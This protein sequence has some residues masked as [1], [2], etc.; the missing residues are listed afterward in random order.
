MKDV[1]RNTIDSYEEFFGTGLYLG[2]FWLAV[3]ALILFEKE[4]KKRE[5][6]LGQILVFFAVYLFPAS[7]YLIM[8]YCIGDTVY[9]RMFWLLP[10]TVMISY[11][12][13][14]ALDYAK[15]RRRKTVVAALLVFAVIQGGSPVYN[16][17]NFSIASNYYK[18][19]QDVL[20]VCEAVSK[21][22]RANG[23]EKK[24]LVVPNQLATE[25]RQYD[26]SIRMPY[27]RNAI[28]GEKISKTA[29]RIY[30]AVNGGNLDAAALSYYAKKGGYPYFAYMTGEKAEEIR[31]AGYQFVENV[32]NYDIYRLGDVQYGKK[33][34]LITQY[35]DFEG[36]QSMF[37]TIR[38]YK[39]RLVV[40]DGGWDV[41]ADSV[42]SKIKSMGGSVDAWILTH[43]HDDHIGAFCEIYKNP[44]GIKIK[45]V[46]AVDMAAPELCLKN[47]PWDGVDMYQRFLE[48][49]IP[50]LKLLHAG[51]KI[52]KGQIRIEVLNAYEDKTDELSDDLL[53]DGS[54]M[55]LVK[56]KTEKMLFCSDV[57]KSMSTYLMEKYGDIL[58]C[59]YVQ[60]G[61]HG[62][63]GLLPEFYKKV[64]PDAAFFDAPGWLFYDTTGTYNTPEKRKLM[65]S[66]GCAIYSF[67]T[68]PNSIVLK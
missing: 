67:E 33:D 35:G 7:A 63:G 13:T 32:G 61:H 49:E 3:A 59:E 36:N 19:N 51:D 5:F 31:N 53:N 22:A 47:A 12:F 25:I 18:L 24:G 45:K 39:N 2:L 28:R 57:G 44:D 9:W 11:L 55:F 29:A 56:G 17:Q 8:R 50:N 68:T 52:K 26:A 1:L 30:D 34:L 46:Y 43:P 58:D 15:G 60:M 42:R 64:S 54:M 66:I 20:A 65:E 62:N 37:Y 38:D 48:L 41:N 6:F 14:N 40:V 10:V 27:G 21:D 23:I 16:E 4:K